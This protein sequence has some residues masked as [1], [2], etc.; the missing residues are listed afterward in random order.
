M[1]RPTR[2]ST[3]F[4]HLLE[5]R[6]EAFVD[7]QDH[8]LVCARDSAAVGCLAGGRPWIFAS[9]AFVDGGDRPCPLVVFRRVHVEQ[10]PAV[11]VEWRQI[12]G[13]NLAH[14]KVHQRF[15]DT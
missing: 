7:G 9:R 3:L 1:L 2:G 6:P 4:E 8:G 12:T 14:C 15:A 11:R 10:Q 5:V 13:A